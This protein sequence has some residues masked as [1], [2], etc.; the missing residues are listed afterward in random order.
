[1]YYIVYILLCEHHP[2]DIRMHAIPFGKSDL[3]W[4]EPPRTERAGKRSD[5]RIKG[6]RGTATVSRQ[7]LGSL[8]SRLPTLATI[9]TRCCP[10]ITYFLPE[11][12]LTAGF[13]HCAPPHRRKKRCSVLGSAIHKDTAV[14]QRHGG[15]SRRPRGRARGSRLPACR[16]FLGPY[17]AGRVWSLQPCRKGCTCT[18]VGAN[19]SETRLVV[20][21]IHTYR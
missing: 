19:E 15:G 4:L 2:V 1:M 18:P 7:Q 20:G 12:P 17:G 14:S 11:A 8:E 10:L 9:S 5:Y 3:P 21:I 13:F 16:C 6:Q